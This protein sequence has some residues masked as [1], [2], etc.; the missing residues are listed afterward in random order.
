MHKCTRGEDLGIVHEGVDTEVDPLGA[1]GLG[2]EFDVNGIDASTEDETFHDARA[3]NLESVFL[4]LSV[5]LSD[6]RAED[7]GV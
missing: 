6:V 4:Y 3:P 7:R 2:A 5:A 1:L